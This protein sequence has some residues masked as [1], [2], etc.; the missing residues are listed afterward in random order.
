MRCLQKFIILLELIFGFSLRRIPEFRLR[1][2]N[3]YSPV[4]LRIRDHLLR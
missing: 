1:L 3:E 4:Y 2:I